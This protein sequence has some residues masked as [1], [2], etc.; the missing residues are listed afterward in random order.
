M[1]PWQNGVD[2]YFVCLKL[3]VH[4]K[5]IISVLGVERARVVLVAEHRVRVAM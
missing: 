1:L 4:R 2:F 5:K 3:G